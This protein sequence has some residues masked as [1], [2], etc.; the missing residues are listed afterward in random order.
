[1]EP[2]TDQLWKKL[3]LDRSASDSVKIS[4]MYSKAFSKFAFIFKG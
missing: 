3:N 1:M 4:I 2:T